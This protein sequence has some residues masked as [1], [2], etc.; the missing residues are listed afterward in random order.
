MWRQ[1]TG[2]GGARP[3]SSTEAESQGGPDGRKRHTRDLLTD[4]M[5]VQLNKDNLA[6][7]PISGLSQCRNG[8]CLLQG[9]PGRP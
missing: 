6:T 2:L 7:F 1:A 8:D 4:W 3:G 9:V 5:L